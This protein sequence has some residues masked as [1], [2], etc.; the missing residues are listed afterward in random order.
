M[1]SLICLIYVFHC[2]RKLLSGNYVSRSLSCGGGEDT[3]D[4][5]EQYNAAV[6]PARDYQADMQKLFKE[7][8]IPYIQDQSGL[9]STYGK[10]IAEGQLKTY[11][12]VGLPAYR[13]LGNKL[14]SDVTTPWDESAMKSVFDKIWQQTREK[15]AAEYAPIEQRTSQRL[16]G[17]GALDTGASIKAF[18]D[19]E[20]SKYKSLETQ[21]I[22]QALQEYNVK[23]TAKQT[24]Y[25][26]MF[27]YLNYQ[28]SVN[29]GAISGVGNYQPQVIPPY[30]DNSA[31]SDLSGLGTG[32]GSLAGLGIGAA[33]APATGGLS[34]ASSLMY[35]M[36]GSA[37]GSM[38]GGGFG[39]LIKY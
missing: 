1:I 33:L 9:W 31:Q 2:I 4:Q 27:K 18:G 39:S 12:D 8:Y 28:P 10:P 13:D 38:A 16:A 21:A 14:S 35:P 17:A 20:Q 29:S 5:E 19:I 30:I 15:T 37:V 7:A 22:D 25:E 32:V 26:N 23:A 36:V 3:S 6:Q 34:L 24:S 11:M